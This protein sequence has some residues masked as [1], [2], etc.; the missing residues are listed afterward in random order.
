MKRRS[1]VSSN[2]VEGIKKR[3]D[4]NSAPK[5]KSGYHTNGGRQHFDTCA[6]CSV[7]GLT[8]A[9]SNFLACVSPPLHFPVR[10]SWQLAL[11]SVCLVL[12]SVL[13]LWMSPTQKNKDVIS[14]WPD[15]DINNALFRRTVN[16]C[17]HMYQQFCRW[18]SW[19]NRGGLLYLHMEW[20]WGLIWG[21][22]W[23]LEFHWFL[24]LWMFWILGAQVDRERGCLC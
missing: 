11:F 21:L 20:S 12:V 9:A 8:P 24:W 18:R 23:D 1:S 4:S 14:K 10:L 2:S 13:I 5:N 19:W 15:N 17:G 3:I 7:E 22:S 16:V 6:L